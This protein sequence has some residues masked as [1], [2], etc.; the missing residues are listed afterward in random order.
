MDK[1]Y[2]ILKSVKL[3]FQK[4]V[5]RQ[6]LTLFCKLCASGLRPFSIRSAYTGLALYY[7]SLLQL[8]RLLVVDFKF[9][10]IGAVIKYTKT[11]IRAF[12]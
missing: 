11:G 12:N 2:D 10:Y 1:A 9:I 8:L 7:R 4:N 6:K 5:W 3:N